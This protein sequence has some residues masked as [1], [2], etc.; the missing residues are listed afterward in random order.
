MSDLTPMNRQSMPWPVRIGAGLLA[1]ALASQLPWF[2][3]PRLGI[4]RGVVL[5]LI[6]ALALAAL[7]IG[8]L[9]LRSWSGVAVAGS[10]ANLPWFV[11]MI[12]DPY[13]GRGLML[14]MAGPYLALAVA[15]VIGWFRER[16]GRLRWLGALA[17]PI[18]YCLPF[19]VE[20]V[21]DHVRWGPSPP[22]G[23]E[24]VFHLS[25][26]GEIDAINV[27][28]D[29]REWRWT[30][31]GCDSSLDERKPLKVE[32]SKVVL[33]PP[34]GKEAFHWITSLRFH[35]P[36]VKQVTLEVNPDGSLR[37]TGTDEGAPFDHRLEKGRVCAI[38]TGDGGPPDVVWVGPRGLR[39]CDGPVPRDPCQ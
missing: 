22:P 38:C 31:C 9:A 7:P 39:A 37:A 10:L 14:F 30:L 23:F 13:A 17:P 20:G 24:G 34:P 4:S 5:P 1:L 8:Y 32:G 27:E 26:P 11:E 12:V 15:G 21:V 35:P 25:R 36:T 18:L 29:G 19:A 6:L 16:A 33:T 3:V 28:F 2:V